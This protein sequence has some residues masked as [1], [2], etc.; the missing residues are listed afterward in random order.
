MG[1]KRGQVAC[2]SRY[3][4]DRLA[5]SIDRGVD[6]YLLLGAGLDNFTFRSPLTEHVHVA[7]VDHPATQSWKLD[8]LATLGIPI[9]TQADLLPVD[10]E[11]ESLIDQLARTGFEPTRPAV[12]TWPP[13]PSAR[14]W[15]QYAAS[16]RAASSSWTTCWPT[17]TA[18]R[19]GRA[20]PAARQGAGLIP[21]RPLA[22]KT[23]DPDTPRYSP[24]IPRRW[25]QPG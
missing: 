21:D 5:E 20:T 12:V 17:S 4:E 23:S 3:A 10:L 16:P 11:R 14:P 1:L 22:I 18:T 25:V 15:R 13:R 19:Q 9:P 7:E 2:H 24:P 6:Q 8:R